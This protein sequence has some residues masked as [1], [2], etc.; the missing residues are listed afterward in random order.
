MPARRRW[1]GRDNC[2]D[3][4]IGIELEGLEGETFEEAQYAR[5]RPRLLRASRRAIRSRAVA[6]H[7]HIA[8]GRKHDPGAGFDWAGCAPAASPSAPLRA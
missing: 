4:S 3:F 7:E 6:G 5:A 8:P 2:N 1:R